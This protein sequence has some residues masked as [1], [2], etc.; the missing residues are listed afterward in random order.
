MELEEYSPDEL[1]KLAEEKEE[2]DSEEDVF[3]ITQKV[4]FEIHHEPNHRSI[5]SLF[6]EWKDG[7]IL[8]S[9]DYQRNF[10]WNKQKSTNLIESIFLNIP[11]PVIFTSEG[12]KEEVIDGQQRLTSIFSFIDGK[13]PNGDDFKL[14]KL[15]ILK[16]L[17]GKTYQDLCNEYPEIIKKFK[18]KTLQITIIKKTSQAD[19]KFEMFERLNI[20][21]T[22]LNEQ[23]LRNCLYRGDYNNF[24]KEFAKNKDFQKIL[25]SPKY[26]IRMLDVELALMFCAFHNKH[27]SKFKGSVKQFLNNDMKKYQK[28]LDAGTKKELEINFKKSIEIIKD[29]FGDRAFKVFNYNE[30]MKEYSFDSKKLNQGLYITLMLGFIPYEKSQVQGHYDLIREELLNLQTHNSEF[31]DTLIGAGTNKKEK[32]IKK[33][34]IWETTLKN[35]LGYP[36]KEPRAFSREL[37]EKLFKENPTCKLCKQR[38]NNVD[39]SEVD[40]IK[41]YWEGAKTIPENA[42]LTHRYCNRK[43][44]GRSE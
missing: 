40:H 24:L 18:K 14:R 29:V 6:D 30:K 27:Y 11:L 1:R 25:D 7:D 44:S 23:E 34:D 2:E 37:K 3:E 4:D 35:V 13:Y 15:K 5:K 9:P 19:V 43:K 33:L 16:H 36:K 42:Q 26:S 21:I 12:E 31:L 32:I 39:D 41:C 17:E 28:N 38:I 8:L 10:V 20:N 22:K